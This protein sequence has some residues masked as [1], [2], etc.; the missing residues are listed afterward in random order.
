MNT[1]WRTRWFKIV[2]I[3]VVVGG[4]Y[5]AFLIQ[6][7]GYV[8][9]RS[10]AG[11]GSSRSSVFPQNMMGGTVPSYDGVVSKNMAVTGIAESA[12]GM[13][14]P[15]PGSG[16]GTTSAEEAK[17][18]QTGYLEIEVENSN[19]AVR[20]I[21]T[22]AEA[23]KGFLISS[24]FSE[25]PTGERRASAQIK[26]PF[27]KFSAAIDEIKQASRFVARESIN[28]QDVTE[29]YI[30]LQSQLKNLRAEETQY[31]GIMER[32][33]KIEDVLNVAS[34]L[35][36]VRGR[37]ESIEGR[38]KYYDARTDFS[39]INVEMTEERVVTAPADKWRPLDNMKEQ[40]QLLIVRLQDFVD[41]IVAFA[42]WLVGVIPYLVIIGIVV[43]VI[44]KI[45]SRRRDRG[46]ENVVRKG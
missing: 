28:S 3:I 19:D 44:K 36:D 46:V 42:F 31:I 1:F 10:V 4:L 22:I 2:A 7:G 37:I 40:I 20:Q 33:T 15:Y 12:Q 25:S 5:L 38:I 35:A 30:D 23:H 34:R 6:T 29:E 43:W 9:M 17:V 41:N 26:V 27:D 8:S 18:I 45:V 13:M 21:R 14:P 24:N 32:A 16:A 39:I 11:L